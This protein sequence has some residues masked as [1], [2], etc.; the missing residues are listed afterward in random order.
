[1]IK[2]RHYK[3]LWMCAVKKCSCCGVEKDFS[4]F[5]KRKAS[6]DGMTASCKQCLK[7]RDSERYANE[8]ERR[9]E[10]HKSYMKTDT[11]KLSHSNASKKW[12][13]ANQ[14]RRA[15]HVILNNAVRDGR[16]EKLPCFVCG[17]EQVEGHHPDYDSPLDVVWLC[18]AHHREIH[19]R[20]PR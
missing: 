19:L 9:S 17:N 10:W 8:K 6:K 13:A 16:I 2:S 18:Q 12:R 3:H 14:V 11:G 20:H 4:E 5:Q 1:M 15:A 7:K